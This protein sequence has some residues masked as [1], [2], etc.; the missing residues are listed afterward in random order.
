MA[1]HVKDD[2]RAGAPVSQ[3][4]AAWFNRV[5]SFL[6]NLVG[7][8]G[9]TVEKSERG[10]S[11][12]SL[13]ASVLTKSSAAPETPEAAEDLT[14]AG[15]GT[16]SAS[17]ASWKYDGATG[18]KVTVQTRTCYIHTASAPALYGFYR[19]F[20]FD[21][22]G[23]LCSVSEETRYVIDTPVVGNITQ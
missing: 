12:V 21:A 8:Y 20:L 9:V 18:V 17:S 19:T 4:P 11:T 7:G 22:K 14:T 6:N 15:E 16:V 3:V 23:M 2:F 10:A 13:D 5:G 1:F